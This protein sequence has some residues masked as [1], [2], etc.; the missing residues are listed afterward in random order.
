MSRKS[1]PRA[2]IGTDEA[3]PA[4]WLRTRLTAPPA[5]AVTS[6]VQSGFDGYVKILHPI[7]VGGDRTE[8]IRWADVVLALAQA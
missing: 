4:D 3:T 2:E 5:N 1:S 7:P 6:W 8:T